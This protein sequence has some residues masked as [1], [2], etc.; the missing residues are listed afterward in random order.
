MKDLEECLTTI[1]EKFNSN[2][3]KDTI[4][5]VTQSLKTM[6]KEH[7]EFEQSINEEI[8]QLNRCN[9][10]LKCDLERLNLLRARN[11]TSFQ[12]K[13]NE[14][15]RISRR[16]IELEQDSE[17]MEFKIGEKE[18]IS[19]KLEE[20]IKKLGHPSLDELYF[21]IVKGFGVEFY[22]KDG[23]VFVKIQNRSKN[24]VLTIECKDD[25]INSI[26]DSIWNNLND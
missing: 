5:K 3:L 11:A 7:K 13:N 4:Y 12:E 21:E 20:D 2:T 8:F 9:K 19:S 26:C 1:N 22:K 18:T 24:D 10:Q 6:E 15:F 17:R 23:K 25:D 16:I 14:R